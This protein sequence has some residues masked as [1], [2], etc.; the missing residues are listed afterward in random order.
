MMFLLELL[1]RRL[2]AFTVRRYLNANRSLPRPLTVL[3][4]V[5]VEL[6]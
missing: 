5:A 2:M 3:G 1:L 4:L 6:L